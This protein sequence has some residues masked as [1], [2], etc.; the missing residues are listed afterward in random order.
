MT[1]SSSKSNSRSLKYK[2]E[3]S[4][5]SQSVV[6]RMNDLFCSF[7]NDPST[8]DFAVIHELWPSCPYCEQ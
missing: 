7:P 4:T 8:S 1:S 6:D 5:R 3:Y 2:T